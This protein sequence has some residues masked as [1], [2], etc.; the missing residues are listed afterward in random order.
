LIFVIADVGKDQ[1]KRLDFIDEIFNILWSILDSVPE[2]LE[3]ENTVADL[4]RDRCD[5]DSAGY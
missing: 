1:A 2:F 3:L 5:A 4:D